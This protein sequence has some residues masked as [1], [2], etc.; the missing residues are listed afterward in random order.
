MLAARQLP[1]VMQFCYFLGHKIEIEVK[2]LELA[3]TGLI[4]IIKALKFTSNS[5]KL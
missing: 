2:N 4:L 3:K 1:I 5:E